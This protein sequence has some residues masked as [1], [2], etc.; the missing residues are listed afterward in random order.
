MPTNITFDDR[1][2][3]HLIYSPPNGWFLG[4]YN[5]T[6]VGQTGTL[7]TSKLTNGL[8]VSFLFPVPATD[9]YYFGIKRCCGG[10]Y[11]ICIDCDP[12][13]PKPITIDGVD[14]TDNGQN[15]PVVLFSRH[16]TVPGIHAVAL[17]NT[18][19][20]RFGG[21]S[22]I[23]LSSFVITVPDTDTSTT[24]TSSS[25]STPAST[26]GGAT[27]SA[28]PSS[29]PSSSNLPG[30]IGGVLGGLAFLLIVAGTWFWCWRRSRRSPTLSGGQAELGPPPHQ[31]A[32]PLDQ[33]NN[34]TSPA[35]ATTMSARFQRR[36]FHK[37]VDYDNEFRCPA[38]RA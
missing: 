12:I 1:D 19:D 27:A 34:V 36:G 14:P 18:D 9:F 24:G 29:S 13:N 11:S 35:T 26:S 2:T 8:N 15:P 25:S 16:F 23:T 6:S 20:Q 37:S 17:A 31:T 21:N 22:Q 3:T 30:I 4:T 28:S 5:A 32:A 38:P 7:A 33:N 10:L